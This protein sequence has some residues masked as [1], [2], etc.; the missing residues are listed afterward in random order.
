[1][2]NLKK[3]EK[4][5]ILTFFTLIIASTIVSSFQ[6]TNFKDLDSII[7]NF[8]ISPISAIT[9]IVCVLLVAKGKISNYIW[10][11]INAITYGYI[12]Y[13]CGYYGDMLLNI[14]WFVPMQLVGF[15]FWKKMLKTDSKTDVKMK[16]LTL[17]QFIFILGIGMIFTMGLGLILS[18][19]NGWFVEVMQRNVSIYNYLD[20]VTGISFLG[21]MLDASTETLQIIATILMT[22]AFREQWLFWILTNIISITLWVIVLIADFTTIS[23]VAPILLMWIAFLINSIY[24]YIEWSKGSGKNA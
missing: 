23:F 10:G 6:S 12:A 18:Y 19:V 17:K 22:L 11:L 9:G 1:M 4:V 21:E 13:R 5:W 20:Q 2:K 15:I 14:V 16:R 3:F 8:V 7:L 24:G